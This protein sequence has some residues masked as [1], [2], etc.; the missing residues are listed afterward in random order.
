MA[1]VVQKFGGT[2]VADIDRIKKVASR[3]ASARQKWDEVIV[4]VSAMAGDTDRLIGMAKELSD[5]PE[6]REIDLLLASGERITSALLA[7]ALEGLGVSAISLTGSQAGIMT[8]GAHTRA[9]VRTIQPKRIRRELEEGRVVIAAGFQG[10]DQLNEEQTLGR[11]GSDLTAVALAA[12]LEADLCEI[13]TDVKGVYTADP[14]IAPRAKLLEKISYDEMMELA[15]LGAKVLQSRSVDLAAKH[16][17]QLV[18]RS[19]FD[20]GEGTLI[21]PDEAGFEAPAVNGV[22]CDKKQSKITALGVADRPGIA[23]SLF[24]SL[25][26]KSIAVDMIVQNV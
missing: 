21:T 4:V 17:L 9:R 2:S 12:A 24:G 14:R 15:S 1:L 8:E 18:V 20:E 3:V 6:G 5:D 13:Y 11:G 25:A 23:A 26:E 7:I 16:K 22:S 19:S 10:V